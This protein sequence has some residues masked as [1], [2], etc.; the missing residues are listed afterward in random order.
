MLKNKKK[1]QPDLLEISSYQRHLW[2]DSR[3]T[4]EARSAAPPFAHA[5]RESSYT[6]IIISSMAGLRDAAHV[7]F[8][9][10]LL[11]SFCA[12]HA[13]SLAVKQSL[14]GQMDE[15]KDRGRGLGQKLGG[16][17]G[18]RGRGTAGWHAYP[19]SL[20]KSRRRRLESVTGKVGA[21]LLG[22]S[23]VAN[24]KQQRF[25]YRVERFRF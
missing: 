22:K 3:T 24:Q 14:E 8:G 25:G 9:P 21:T 15:W 7:N 17:G 4:A 12:K 6:E 23:P 10:V 13:A 16:G 5:R 1:R 11:N 18:I 2:I 19:R 20:Y